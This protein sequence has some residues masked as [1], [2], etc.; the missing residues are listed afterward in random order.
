MSTSSPYATHVAGSRA[1]FWVRA[2]AVILDGLLVSIVPLVLLGIGL[3]ADTQGLVAASYVLWFV[4]AIAYDVYYHG[5]ESG[6]TIGKRVTGIRVIDSRNG[7]PIGY[8]RSAVR[9]FGRYLSGLVCYL[10]YLWM[11]WD[12]EKQCWHDKMANDLVVPV[13]EFPVR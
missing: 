11:L 10:G 8:G 4:L 2:G 12:T 6:Q 1:G 13:S 9:F 3:A 5:G 7:G